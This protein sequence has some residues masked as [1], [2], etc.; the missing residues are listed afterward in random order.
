YQPQQQPLQYQPQLQ[1]YP[2]RNPE[3]EAYLREVEEYDHFWEN[4]HA[5][6]ATYYQQPQR[7]YATD[8]RNNN[9]GTSELQQLN[10]QLQASSAQNQQQNVP[11]YS[12]HSSKPFVVTNPTQLINPMQQQQQ[13]QQQQQWQQGA[14]QQ[15]NSGAKS[16][17]SSPLKSSNP[18]IVNLDTLSQS[19][20][21]T[22][23]G[24]QR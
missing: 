9:G 10:P 5:R 1:P 23:F 18:F 20:F 14:L 8:I 7:A 2:T 15:Q 6:T 16:A 24:N 4:E 11:Y 21:G 12:A 3:D 22:I 17:T 19:I 13:Q